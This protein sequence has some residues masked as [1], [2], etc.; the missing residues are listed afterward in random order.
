MFRRVETVILL[1]L[2]TDAAVSVMIHSSVTEAT[3]EN[4][5][6]LTVPN[7]PIL[8]EILQPDQHV[9]AILCGKLGA[10]DSLPTNVKAK[11][12]T[13][14]DIVLFFIP[15]LTGPNPS[16]EPTYKLA[17]GSFVSTKKPFF[18][19]I[20]LVIPT[21]QVD[22]LQLRPDGVTIVDANGGLNIT[23]PQ[24]C[25]C[26]VPDEIIVHDF[27]E[28]IDDFTIS[29]KS[30]PNFSFC[31]EPGAGDDIFCNYRN[32][33]DCPCQFWTHGR[34]KKCKAANF[35]VTNITGKFKELSLLIDGPKDAVLTEINEARLTV[36]NRP[37]LPEI[38][39]SDQ[40][41][42]LIAYG[43]LGAKSIED[44]L[45]TNVKAKYETKADTVHFIIPFL[46]GTNPSAEPTYNL[47]LG[48]LVSTI[49]PFI[50]ANI[51][52]PT[53]QVDLLE[54]RPDGVTIID[55][56]E[57][58]NITW[59][60]LCEC[61]VPDEIIRQDF[62]EYLGEFTLPFKSNQDFSLCEEPGAGDNVFCKYRNITDCACQFWTHGYT[63][64]CEAANFSVTNITGKFKEV[65]LLIDG[66]Q[67]AVLTEINEGLYGIGVREHCIE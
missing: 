8:P 48:T 50:H 30:N 22:L 18:H 36:P 41:V 28:Y 32:T 7:R 25:E 47:V 37:V 52:I 19:A 64:K 65:S 15:F 40:H 58:F 55:A 34:T 12:E 44:S 1:A 63:K 67:D 20:N 45:P 66:P 62:E 29:F 4:G 51:V 49:K 57:V 10:K 24:L 43:K 23:W 60:Q 14:A 33:I 6:R 2:C 59:P 39:Q 3:W 53:E 17:L 16:A 13:K 11:Y 38:L 42:V 5:P 9:V 46:T 35:S 61:E 31:D 56:N 21:E 26:E 27:E 54:V